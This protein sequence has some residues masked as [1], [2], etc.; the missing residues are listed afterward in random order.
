VL[1]SDR[2]VGARQRFSIAVLNGLHV[3]A[4]PYRNSYCIT[5]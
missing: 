5:N 4:V 1:D 2:R 3:G